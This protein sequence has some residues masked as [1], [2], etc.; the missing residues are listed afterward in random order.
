ME[1][2]ATGEFRD[3][4]ICMYLHVRVAGTTQQPDCSFPH[5]LASHH[6]RVSQC[7]ATSLR[8]I[9][10]KMIDNLLRSQLA[11]TPDE[12]KEDGI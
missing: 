9:E 11:S 6:R 7:L 12:C 3:V 10:R 5:C 8:W 1:G 4:D 2:T